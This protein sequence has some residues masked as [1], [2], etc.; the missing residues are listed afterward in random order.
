MADSEI[1]LKKIKIEHSKSA[2]YSSYFATG[3]VMSGPSET[4]IMHLIFYEDAININSETGTPKKEKGKY[5]PSFEDGDLSRIR[6]D[7]ARI[8]MQLPTL[9]SLYELL[10]T[11][12]SEEEQN[13]QDLPEKE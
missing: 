8:S 9:L 6:E 3:V 2:Q 12:F 4:G 1:S 13:K 10:K 5:S 11:R 7:K